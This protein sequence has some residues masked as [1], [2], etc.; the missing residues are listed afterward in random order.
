MATNSESSS[1]RWITRSSVSATS[2]RCEAHDAPSRAR[3]ATARDAAS[4]HASFHGERGHLLRR[5]L[6]DQFVDAA[7][8]LHAVLIEL[9]LPQQA[10]EHR[11]PQLLLGGEAARR[12]ALVCAR[13]APA[14]AHSTSLH[15]SGPCSASFQER[16]ARYR[17][18]RELRE[19]R[20]CVRHGEICAGEYATSRVPS[21]RSGSRQRARTPAKRLDFATGRVIGFV[22]RLPPRP[23]REPRSR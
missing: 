1:A 16:Q 12:R 18:W 15:S 17:A 3:A 5:D 9:A 14:S 8:D 2:A 11:A 22:R 19:T 21:L 10:G 6:R 7:G 20:G 4:S 13:T 23:V